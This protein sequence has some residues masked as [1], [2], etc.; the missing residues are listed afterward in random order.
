MTP[1]AIN[2]LIEAVGYAASA[3]VLATFC[4]SDPVR[5]RIFALMSNIAFIGFGF[6]G[7]VYPVMVL[8]MILLPIN[9]FHLAKLVMAGGA[10]HRAMP[11]VWARRWF[12]VR[13]DPIRSDRRMPLSS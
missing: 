2:M 7:A 3:L 4:F 12:T 11:C 8:H 10:P 13:C 9:S 5:L 6:L 1:P